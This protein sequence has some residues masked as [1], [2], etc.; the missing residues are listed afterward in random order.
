[1][2]IE[3]SA[4]PY[5]DKI[6]FKKSHEFAENVRRYVVKIL[7]E[8]KRG[9]FHVSESKLN[10]A[11]SIYFIRVQ[12][13]LRYEFCNATDNCAGYGLPVKY[14]YIWINFDLLE[15][16]TIFRG[17]KWKN[18]LK[19][20]NSKWIHETKT[21][22]KYLHILLKNKKPILHACFTHFYVHFY[23]MK[24]WLNA[25]NCIVRIHIYHISTFASPKHTYELQSAHFVF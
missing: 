8:E 24:I 5:V 16:N 18:F 22:S 19:K 2:F 6:R 9:V 20:Y 4:I 1:M 15:N 7:A 10:W 11:I 13:G 14:D 17:K 21:C 12:N 25:H 23:F 3:I